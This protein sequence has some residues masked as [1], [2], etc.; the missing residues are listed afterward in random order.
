[1]ESKDYIY[2]GGII[3]TFGLGVWNFI[4]GHRTTRKASFINTVTSQR[5]KWI[6]QLRQ[7]IAAFS[8]C[9]H[10][11]HMSNLKGTEKEVEIL[12]EI[13]RLRHLIR[14]RLNPDGVHDRKITSLINEIPKLTHISK[15]D[16]LMTALDQ[17]TI[18]TQEMLKEEWEKV[19]AEAKDGDLKEKCKIRTNP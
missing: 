13:D 7:D 9:T 2:L 3:V 11:W 5:I 17:L 10:T 6:E 1:M 14:L 18:A 12:K 8:G 19:K 15:R 16:E 4:Q